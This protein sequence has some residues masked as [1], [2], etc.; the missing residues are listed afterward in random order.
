MKYFPGHTFQRL[1][2]VSRIDKDRW[3]CVCDC[4]TKTVKRIGDMRSGRSGSCGCL[5]REKMG[6]FNRSKSTHNLSGTP[7]YSSWNSMMERCFSPKA[8]KWKDYGARGIRPC[9]FIAADPRNLVKIIGCRTANTSID[10]IENSL[11]YFC[12]QCQECLSK[13]QPRNIRW[14]TASQQALNKTTNHLITIQ[15]STKALSEWSKE[16]GIF[17]L[18]LAYRHNKGWS[19]DRIIQQP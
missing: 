19:D 17:R 6:E 15:G 5:H 11:G 2:L 1:T 13:H 7:T 12:G 14:A 9:E 4:G 16:L 8:E 3:H 10:R 18:T